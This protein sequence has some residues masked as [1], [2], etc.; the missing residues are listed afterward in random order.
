MPCPLYIGL[1]PGN[2]LRICGPKNRLAY[3]PS[4]AH[5]KLLCLSVSVYNECPIYKRKATRKKEVYGEVGRES[6]SIKQIAPFH[7]L[8][9]IFLS[10]LILL[11]LLFREQIPLYRLLRSSHLAI[12]E[13]YHWQAI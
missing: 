4:S 12:K 10:G 2:P 7:G 11:T 8:T 3:I 1:S 6:L 9:L 13:P 5:L